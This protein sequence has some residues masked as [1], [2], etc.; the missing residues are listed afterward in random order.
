MANVQKYF[1]QFHGTIRI[2][3]E[4]SQPLRDKREI[5]E[6]RITEWLK[7][8][9]KPGL[10]SLLQGSYAMKTGVIPIGSLEYDIDIGLRLDL[11]AEDYPASEVRGWVLAALEGHTDRVEEKGPCIRVG[12]AVGFH[13]DVVCYA[14]WLEGAGE[15]F[16][17]A[18]RDSGW[19]P[20][21]PP[22]LLEAIKKAREPYDG[23]EDARTKT[24]QFRRAVRYLRRWDDVAIP[25]ES[26]AKPSGLAFVLLCSDRLVRKEA[27]S[28]DP[29]DR[30]ALEVLARSAASTPDRL[31]AKKPTPEYEDMFGRLTDTEMVDLKSR[32]SSLAKALADADAEPDPVEACRILRGVFGEDFPVPPPEDTGRRTRTPAIVTPSSSAGV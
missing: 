5:L 28:G 14:Y 18:H 24:D 17:L 27:V 16:N 21:D 26:T 29:D 31:V 32:C 2:D 19:R 8:N 11:R 3:Y 1:E 4:A 9:G 23:T 15:R 13:V 30:A 7:Q 10:S 20:T 22:A 12:Y 6:R 25:K